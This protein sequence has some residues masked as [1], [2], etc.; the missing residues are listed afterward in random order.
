MLEGRRL[1]GLQVVVDCANGAAVAR[2][3]PRCWPQLGAAV[4]VLHADPDGTNINDGC[5]SN[6]PEA[7]QTAVLARG[8]DAGLAF[9]GDADR[10]VAVDAAGELVDGDQLIALLALDLRDRGLLHDDAVAVTVMTNLGFRQAMAAAR[11]PGGRHAR[12]R[13]PRPGRPRGARTCRSAASSRA[14]SSSATGPPP[15]TGCSPAWPC[16]TS[17]PAGA[18]PRRPG[19]RS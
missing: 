5:G 10:V 14:T 17:W 9:D 18:H 12:G 16:S 7:L 4:T 8:A 2:S 13:P 1:A 19:R 6:H 11:H 3:R 15:A